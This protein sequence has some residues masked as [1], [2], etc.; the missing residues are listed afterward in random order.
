MFDR[1][2]FYFDVV[3]GI[4]TLFRLLW[5]FAGFVFISLWVLF[6]CIFDLLVTVLNEVLVC[7]M[8]PGYKTARELVQQS[9]CSTSC[10]LPDELIAEP[11]MNVKSVFPESPILHHPLYTYTYIYTHM[12]IYIY[13]YS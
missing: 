11:P 8:R 12:Y 7:L 1:F 5:M 9:G 2:R 10:A 13:I 3:D 4:S 6:R